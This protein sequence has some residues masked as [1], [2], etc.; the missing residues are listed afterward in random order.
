MKPML[1]ARIAEIIT[2]RRLC[3]GQK[4]RVTVGATSMVESDD[5]GADIAG[6]YVGL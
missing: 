4:V 3:G 6:L 1:E 2:N 5:P